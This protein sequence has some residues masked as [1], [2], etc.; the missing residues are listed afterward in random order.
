MSKVTL[1]DENIF[2]HISQEAN[3]SFESFLDTM[4]I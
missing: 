2:F 4:A 1:M 3:I